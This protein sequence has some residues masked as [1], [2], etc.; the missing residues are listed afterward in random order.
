MNSQDI[1]LVLL[2][3]SYIRSTWKPPGISLMELVKNNQGMLM[4]VGYLTDLTLEDYLKY[5]GFSRI[6]PAIPGKIAR[7]QRQA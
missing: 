5:E 3:S 1:L 7:W 4:Y 2:A 6:F